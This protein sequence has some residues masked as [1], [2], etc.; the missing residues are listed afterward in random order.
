MSKPFFSQKEFKLSDI[1]S[2]LRDILETAKQKDATDISILSGFKPKYG[3]AK[4]YFNMPIRT[5][6]QEDIEIIIDQTAPDSSW[7]EDIINNSAYEYSFAIERYGIY[8]VSV[9]LDSS[10]L[11]MAIRVLSYEIPTVQMLR[12]PSEV[13]KALDNAKAGLIIHTGGTTSGK[14]TAMAA[15]MGYLCDKRNV[16]M[17][18]FENP[19]EYRFLYRKAITRQFEVPRMV[20]S[21]EHALKI[22][23]RSDPSIILFGEARTKEEIEAMI[24]MAARGHLVFSTFH[25]KNVMSTLNF[26]Y[27]VGGKELLGLFASQLVV[28]NSQYLYFNKRLNKILPFYDILIPN[29]PIKTMMQEAKFGDVERLRAEGKIQ[30]GF[31]LTFLQMAQ[32]YLKNNELNQEEYNEILGRLLE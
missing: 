6:S 1:S 10:G 2:L 16:I 24:D 11:G 22:A 5:I 7:R 3:I 26:L 28:L 15:E 29:K 32:N 18:S 19:I 23:L 4:N 9:S 21:F 17:L 30:N 13:I 27:Q 20:K 8:R 31:S 12:L 14:S 25:T